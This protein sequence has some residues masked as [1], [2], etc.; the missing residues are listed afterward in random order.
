[1]AELLTA[2]NT[3]FGSPEYANRIPESVRT[4]ITENGFGQEELTTYE[5][6]EIFSVLLNK[7]AKQDIYSF[8]FRDV[9]LTRFDKGY[10]PYGDIFEDDY[11]DV[12]TAR[13]FPTIVDGTSVDPYV[14]N[15]PTVRPS[16]YLGTYDLQYW[17][18]TRTME[19]KKA[20]ICER[21]LDSFIQR[22][23][24][25]LP[26]SLRLD[27]YLILRNM[28]ATM[29]YAKTFNTNVTAPT[30][31]EDFMTMLT[32]DEVQNMIVQISMASEAMS[33]S[34]TAY[35][36]LGVMNSTPKDRQVLFINAGVYRLMKAVL[37][38]AYH[39]AINFGIADSNIIEISGFGET[40]A[41]NGIYA[42]LVDEAALKVYTT[43]K[44][45]IENIY[46]PAGK[47]WNS[48]LSYQGK[49]AYSRHANSAKFTI[50]EA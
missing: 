38:N 8:V 48:W 20:F 25:V 12:T 1:M 31:S 50:T 22:A 14:V 2:I 4:K 28:L 40:A 7:F 47:Y 33:R 24:S 27:R 41:A 6:N 43:E 10:V 21:D 5:A 36:S 13:A 39:D 23:R 42:V 11:I 37:Y 15:L 34:S 32:A 19:V 16:Y 18:T 17:T 44:P 45:D 9:D 26:E 29:D 30:D 46:N 35:N 49:T 3:L